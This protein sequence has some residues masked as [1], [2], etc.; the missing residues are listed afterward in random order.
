MDKGLGRRRIYLV[1]HGSSAGKN[2]RTG[3]NLGAHRLVEM[4]IL[5]SSSVSSNAYFNTSC[6]WKDNKVR[7]KRLR[8]L[9]GLLWLRN[10][11]AMFAIYN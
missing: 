5:L 3:S 9:P 4:L 7:K 8:S 1:K 6:G 10:M 11:C 2:R